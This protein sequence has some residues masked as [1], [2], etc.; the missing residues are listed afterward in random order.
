MRSFPKRLSLT[1]ALATLAAGTVCAEVEVTKGL[2]ISGYVVGSTTATRQTSLDWTALLPAGYGSGQPEDLSQSDTDT[3]TEIDAYKLQAV[4]TYGRFTATGS[5]FSYGTESG[6]GYDYSPVLL[7][8][9]V[10]CDLGGGYSL[11]AGKF[12]SWLGYESFD[13]VNLNQLTYANEDLFAAEP[14]IVLRVT[15]GNGNVI[16]S[17]DINLPSSFA[18]TGRYIDPMF[19]MPA[20]SYHSGLKLER[21]RE[22]YSCGLAVL[23]SVY[24]PAYYRG[25]GDFDN[26]LGFEGF[27]S[28]KGLKNFT[29]FAGLAYESQ[30]TEPSGFYG[31][32]YRGKY[33]TAD[34]WT[35]YTWHSTTFAAEFC[36]AHSRF[37]ASSEA[38]LQTSRSTFR[39]YFWAVM[40]RHA[41]TPKWALTGRISGTTADMSD[42]SVFLY[43]RPLRSY[44][45][46]IAP[47]YAVCRYLDLVAE[48]SYTDY[49]NGLLEHAHFY[50]LQARV[51]F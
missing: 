20:P 49:R 21:T 6:S 39:S 28:Y 7:D 33:L 47:S 38:D 26:G 46:T 43:Q 35:E 3:A 32:T 8:A 25:D 36:W 30:K 2:T 17:I 42:E 9:H 15:D 34:F 1:V 10:S 14:P 37:D 22:T 50:G 44:R 11:T 12:Q 13:A 5:L 4:G 16:G 18:E 23:D 45:Y 40:A 24:G 27:A 29:F 31:T 51:K 41:F 48:Y 19:G